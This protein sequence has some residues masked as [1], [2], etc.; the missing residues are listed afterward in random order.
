MLKS[1]LA[2]L[3]T[4]CVTVLY[5]QTRTKD[6][7]PNL[8]PIACDCKKAVKL[9]LNWNTKYGPTIDTKGYGDIQEIPIHDKH[10][11]YYFETEHNSAWY[12]LNI[13]VDGELVFHIVP[14][15]PIDDYDFLLFKYNDTS[16]CRDFIARKLIPVRSN[17]S[18]VSD[19]DSG[20]TGLSSNA[21]VEYET[22][23]KGFAY[24]KSI[25]VKKGE[26]YMLIL[27]NVYDGGKGHTIFFHIL[28]NYHLIGKT[29]DDDSMPVSATVSI[30]EKNGTVI[31][32]TESDKTTGDYNFT[33][34]LQIGGQYTITYSTPNSFF[35][36]KSFTPIIKKKDTVE[37]K[38][39]VLPALKAN[40]TYKLKNILFYSDS[41][42]ILPQSLPTLK[43]L[44][45]ILTI[46]NKMT[47]RIEGHV[48]PLDG[49]GDSYYEMDLSKRRALT[50][51]N[52]LV[53]KGIKKERLSII[54]F[55]GKFP[56]YITAN[57]VFFKPY[58]P[59]YYKQEG[60]AQQNRR[61]EIRIISMGE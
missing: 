22:R 38:P 20:K 57:E 47:I 6:S 32:K 50:V 8:K 39:V 13:T 51:Y 49:N 14:E 46:H 56:L 3:L 55:G 37:Y 9:T 36:I 10:S 33:T 24:S 30:S 41:D 59:E 40:K 28:K 60:K 48:N 5:S 25:H 31:T 26:Q 27:D 44:Y 43:M 35:D 53:N 17:I 18:R 16:F 34:P 54:G 2:I 12:L 58:P 29:L 61:V 15:N 11:K 19:E 23:G 1:F 42:G 7:I 45:A 4:L 52:Y 21:K